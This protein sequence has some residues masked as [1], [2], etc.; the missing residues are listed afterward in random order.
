MPWGGSCIAMIGTSPV[1][2]GQDSTL[3]FD[4]PWLL[5]NELGSREMPAPFRGPRSVTPQVC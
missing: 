4:G 3:S 1:K 2:P 5:N